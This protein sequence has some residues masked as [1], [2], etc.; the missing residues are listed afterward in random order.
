MLKEA[1]KSPL[2][3]GTVCAHGALSERAA[4]PGALVRGFL[5][6]LKGTGLH[7]DHQISLLPGSEPISLK[8]RGEGGLPP[9]FQSNFNL[10]VFHII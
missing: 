2:E 5:T 8:L 7:Q 6:S 1:G 4:V 3:T 10:L 9:W